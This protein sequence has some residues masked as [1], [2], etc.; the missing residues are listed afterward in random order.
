[1]KLINTSV[2]RPIGVI[3]CVLIALVIGAVSLSELPIDLLP[4]IEIPVAVVVTQYTGAAPE[5]VV[6]LVTKPLEG[7]LSTIQGLDMIQ[8]TSY[9]DQSVIVMLFKFGTKLDQALL[10]IR[11]KVDQGKWVLPDDAGDPM[12]IKMDINAQPIVQLSLSGNIGLERLTQ[13]AEETVQPQLERVQGVA[14][15]SIGGDR[16]KEIR[17]E[18]DPAKLQ[19]YGITISDIAQAIAAN[20]SNMTAGNIIRGSQDINVRLI[21]EYENIQDVKNVMIR[22]ASGQRVKITEIANVIDSFKEQNTFAFVDSETALSLNVSKQS[23]TN[24]VKVANDVIKQVEKIAAS[25]PEGAKLTVIMNTAQF[26]ELAIKNVANSL[27]LGA[28]LAAVVLYLFLRNVRSTLVIA[29][30]MPI[31]LVATFMMMYFANQTVNIL[32]MSGLA[33][34][35]G[36]MVDSSIVILEN[37]YRYR[38]DG[39]GKIEAAI[40]GA[41]E[42]VAPV[43]AAA[44]TTVAAFVPMIFTSGMVAELFRPLALT[45]SF[46]LLASLIVAVTIVPMLS[47]RLLRNVDD[48]TTRKKRRFVRLGNAVSEMYPKTLK[49]VLN[50]KKTTILITTI[51]IIGS[52]ALIPVLKLEFIPDMDQGELSISVSLPTGTKIEDTKAVMIEIEEFMLSNPDVDMILN[53]V[54]SG[55]YDGSVASN[56]ATMYVRL[57][58]QKD[59]IGTTNDF[60]EEIN[61]FGKNYPDLEINAASAS[62]VSAMIGS[63]IAV[64]VTGKDEQIIKAIA[65]EVEAIVAAIPGTTNVVNSLSD[66][67]PE[68]HV[69]IN[70]EIAAE[71]GLA[72]AQVMQI[73]RASFNGQVAS[74]IKADGKEIDI[75]ISLPEGYR[76]D[77][78]QL[79]NMKI[80]TPIGVAV[81][82]DSLADFVMVDGPNTIFRE[83]LEQNATIS[84][85]LLDANLQA[86]AAE[87]NR[88]IAQLNLPE[89]YAVAMGGQDEELNDA[90]AD[91]VL[92]L[93]LAIFLVY[94]VM[95]IQFESLMHPFII[96]FSLPATI[97]GIVVGLL[98]T[99]QTLSVFG[100]I[101]IVMLVGIVVNNA[102]VLVDYVNVLRGRGMDRTE[103]IILAGRHRLR[104]VLMTTLTTVLGMLPISIGMGE[105]TEM[106]QSL[107][108]VI[109]YGLSFSTLITLVLVPVMYMYLDSINQW[110]RKKLTRKQS[111][112]DQQE[113]LIGSSN[114]D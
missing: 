111:I 58:S 15:V 44:L 32:T 75:Y 47:G 13:I 14:Q 114:L 25:L 67:R 68:L 65:E 97:I 23:D 18:P 82:L 73:A 50:H 99:G 31:S 80:M 34:G 16:H 63:P 86:V 29:I 54:G 103:A 3:I 101:G 51:L 83:D 87:I 48:V 105:G 35:V 55:G 22:T 8:S 37:I 112:E 21:G 62:S 78:T 36:M 110:F 53:M 85:D 17:I 56:K 26:I 91:L 90:I 61:A 77:I 84:A 71:Y 74:R 9:T 94:S 109:V 60:I 40:E 38:Q 46:S 57:V 88:V 52:I 33:L 42:V 64:K 39:Y 20:N 72:S 43:I 1:M 49:W 107:G 41:K 6:N 59:R 24:T 11:D 98:I 19:G 106:Q 96:M 45:I 2:K 28:C 12:I 108:T 89:G 69:Q 102:I 81:T 5:E 7:V 76:D 92:A 30:S 100:M 10:D 93:L 79:K 4:N 66:T 104:P 95:A 113:V 70:S 27:L